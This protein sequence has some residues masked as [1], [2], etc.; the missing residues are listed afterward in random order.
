MSRTGAFDWQTIEAEP[1]RSG[2]AVLP[3]LLTRQEGRA[4]AAMYDD[5]SRL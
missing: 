3:A 1:G 4:L 5:E 2:C